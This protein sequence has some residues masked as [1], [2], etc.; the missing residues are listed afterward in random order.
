MIK[1][2]WIHN[3]GIWTLPV[4]PS[5]MIE[6]LTGCLYICG[7]NDSIVLIWQTTMLDLYTF[8]QIILN[9]SRIIKRLV[10]VIFTDEGS[11][12]MEKY[13]L[14]QVYLKIMSCWELLKTLVL[15]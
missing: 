15:I 7:K 3:T 13:V 5:A 1:V 6:N 8:Y 4:F 14:V 12:C 9:N 10:K 11:I 2:C